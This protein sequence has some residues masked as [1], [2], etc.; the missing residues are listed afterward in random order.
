ME[1]VAALIFVVRV[2]CDFVL[3]E[4]APDWL[5]SRGARKRTNHDR[6]AVSESPALSTVRRSLRPLVL[7]PSRSV[8]PGS[9][10]YW[11]APRRAART[12]RLTP[13]PFFF[14]YSPSLRL[15]RHASDRSRVIFVSSFIQPR[16]KFSR[17][18][19][20]G[21]KNSAQVRTIM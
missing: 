10:P 6:R 18:R 4:R 1:T 20:Q 9:R 11:L 5:R 16:R 17:R 2:G 21:G 13:H 12:R 3:F 8:S 15:V 7:R 14:P 19:K